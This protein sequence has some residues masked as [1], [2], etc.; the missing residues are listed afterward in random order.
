[1]NMSKTYTFG[2]GKKI[3]ATQPKE[4]AHQERMRVKREAGIPRYTNDARTAE[5]LAMLRTMR[6]N[7]SAADQAF[8]DQWIAPL[9]T[10][11]DGYGNHWLTIG[12][13]RILWSSHTDTVHR[14]G[15]VQYVGFDSG[16]AY[17][18]RSG[19]LGA[20]D[21]VGVWLMRNM[22]LAG[23][24]GTYVFHRGEEVGA[25]GSSWIER[26]TPERLAGIDFAIA[27]DRKG[28]NEIITDQWGN[29]ASDEFALSLANAL[30]PLDYEPSDRGIFTDTQIYSDIIPECS[31]I[32]VGY[33][34]QHTGDEW[35]DVDFAMLLCDTL[36]AADF[37]GLV[38]ARDPLAEIEYRRGSNRYTTP[39]D[40]W[41]TWQTEP[42]DSL[43]A[44]ALRKA[45][46]DDLRDSTGIRSLDDFCRQ[47]PATASDF[48]N[49]L[50]YDL[51]DLMRYGGLA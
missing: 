42:A 13:S 1:M 50:G 38:V 14:N 34:R 35:L 22:I 11:A 49:E 10:D 7:G 8:V 12:D 43:L 18:T 48:L 40:D 4:T 28:Y 37:S 46:I 31:N 44:A 24:P 9:G 15:G 30:K 29:T 26:N 2:Y 6:P 17:V 51:S 39:M 33:H 32:S 3:A 47:Y 16:C 45:E 41:D 21:T 23:V 5:L 27:F 19:C 36:C 20:D 25:L